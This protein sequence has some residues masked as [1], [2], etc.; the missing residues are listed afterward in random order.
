MDIYTDQERFAERM[1][2]IPEFAAAFAVMLM[3][4]V[5]PTDPVRAQP[6]PA[7]EENS[8]PTE[9]IDRIESVDP[10]EG[11]NRPVHRF[12]QRL[13]RHLVRPVARG[14][15]QVVP[16][17]LRIGI[18]NFFVNLFQPLTAAHQILQGKPGQAASS[19]GRFSLNV[20]LGLGGIFDPATDAGI[21]L[22]Q[23]DLGQ[24]LAVWG[25]KDSRYL[26]LPFL[27]PS[28]PRDG[29][30]TIGDSFANPYQLADD[31]EV[32]IGLR[33]LQLVDLRASFLGAD[34]FVRDVEDDYLIFRDSYLQRRNFQIRDGEEQTPDYLLEDFDFDDF[35]DSDNRQPLDP[36]GDSTAG[37]GSGR[38]D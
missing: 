31:N 4:A 15:T 33:A 16:R 20:V 8:A 17:P 26:V 10:W 22:R 11:F 5:S 3:L 13:D 23:E 7:P 32:R 38:D 28:T 29:F 6:S 2:R 9:R 21:P 12:N 36:A 19:V 30:G 25:W 24:T 14:Y 35:D 37:D 18:S 1:K 27:G 34:Q